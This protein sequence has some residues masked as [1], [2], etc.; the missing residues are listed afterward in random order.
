MQEGFE[1]AYRQLNK[2]Q[3]AAVDAI[4]GPV[5]VVAGP[6]TGKTQLLS[7]RVANILQKTDTEPGNILCLTFTN[8][9]AANMR[10]RLTHLIGAEAARIRVR[11][12]HSFA[13]DIM[14]RYPDYFWQGA[15]L[16]VAP[17][18]VQLEIVQQILAGL[19]LDN[20]LASKFAGNYTALAEVQQALK[21][22]REAG[23][24]PE[25]LAAMLQ[26]NQAY[27]DVIEPRLVEIL[28]APLSLKKLPVL[29]AAVSELPEQTISHAVQ[30]L[31]SLSNVLKESLA[32]A[33]ASDELAGKCTE[34]GK[35]KRRWLQ[36]VADKKGMFD[37]RKR[38]AW[39]QAF[40]PVYEQ[41][42]ADLHAR[43][44]YDYADM[45]VE[46]ISQLEQHPTLLASVQERTWYTLID[47]FQDTNAA[48][49]RL[50]HL[51]AS[52]PNT[53]GKPNLMA[54]GDDDQTIFA[55]NGAELNNM[56]A[57]RRTFP[58][59]HTIVLTQNYRSAQAILDLAEA[60]I[61]QA[62]DRLV[63]RA[64]DLT[65][66]LVAAAKVDDDQLSHQSYPTREHQLAA[67]AHSLQKSWEA[68]E[69]QSIAVLA[70]G[71]DSLRRLAAELIKL[72]V[73]VA[74]E[75]Q[76]N[77][78]EN[79]AVRQILLLTE[80]VLAVQQGDHYTV[81]H[82]L[83]RLLRHH[84]WSIEPL[85]LWQLAVDQ[86]RQSD[87]LSSLARHT[88]EQ[89]CLIGQWLLDL[90]T[91]AEQEPLP[92]LL[93]YLLGLRTTASFTSPLREYYL[94][95]GKI[96][97]Q[98]FVTLSAIRLLVEL[99]NEFARRPRADLAELVRFVKLNESLGRSITDTSWYKSGERAVQL[100]TVHKAKG[101]EFDVVYLLDAVEGEWQPRH[102]GRR[103]PA[104]L[105]LQPYG[106]E[107][108]DYIRLLYVAVTRA[109]R[110]FIASSYS[111]DALGREVLPTPLL[112]QA[113][114]AQLAP[115]TPGDSNIHVLEQALAWPALS[116]TAQQDLLADRL[117]DYQL[118]ATGL[119][120]FLD[121]TSGGPRQ[122]LEKYLL[123]LPEAPT[124]LQAYGTA[125]HTALQTAQ[126]L[127]NANEFTLSA[128]LGAY[129]QALSSQPI[130]RVDVARFAPHGKLVLTDL[131]EAKHFTLPRGGQ[132]EI[133]LSGVNIGEARSCGTIDHVLTDG[134]TLIIMDYKT[135]TPL[136]SFTTR[137][138]T[139]LLKAWRHQYQLLFYVLLAQQ[140]NRF[141]T[142]KTVQ[143]QIAYVEAEH[144]S[145]LLLKL[146][147]ADA[148]LDQLTALV[149]KVWAH[150]Q[151]CNFPDTGHYAQNFTGVEQFIA[152]VLAG[153][154]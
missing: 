129:E 6:G 128:V 137:D 31:S 26:V 108:D 134:A 63:T 130:S 33:I 17:D 92:V 64:P 40:V 91:V 101:L 21:L 95:S 151:S 14:D 75:Q 76:N 78:L 56:L 125:V 112:Q 106:E 97:G 49:L 136:S 23:L 119:L 148:Q 29:Q 68:N 89:L 104:N 81:D 55:F 3:R 60:V 30:P 82:H 98:Y 83:P 93:Q 59:T 5:L 41:Y 131:F 18:A 99:V 38:N 103:P 47:E 154:I 65:K 69:H 25:K 107:L 24:T 62:E 150:I 105:P 80:I 36:T 117:Q 70:R 35:W 20:P 11:T 2:A 46:V 10:G 96:S 48:Q 58:A 73:P 74:Y 32:V 79:E 34:T 90:A 102:I 61:S 94:A 142:A 114:P 147:P 8:H 44:Y 50:A 28:R 72:E 12:F 37:E 145:N 140:S 113:L 152:D 88:D 9:A 7:L 1:A 139:K 71:H 118:S 15:R 4:D 67:A 115:I 126:R 123:A 109:K 16:S 54:V 45:I 149:Q 124:A 42:R 120:Q 146:F 144:A 86:Y 22:T 133:T 141:A 87:W 13:A 121:V 132:A 57:F 143:T 116:D 138:N 19:P 51:V 110:S 43:G 27:L 85:T 153:A 84:M 39:W 66:Q 100:M 52:S 77:I 135:G 111:R 122:F 53:E 127:T